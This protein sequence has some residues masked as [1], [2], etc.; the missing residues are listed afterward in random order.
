MNVIV[1]GCGRIGGD[2]AY[3]LFQSGHQVVVVDQSPAAFQN[4]PE[5]FRGRF[6]EGNAMNMD[7][8]RRAGIEEADA[9]AAVTSSDPLNAVIGHLA[10]S[11]YCVPSV[12]VR[13]YDSRW[14][15]MH[16]LFGLQMVSASSWGAQRIEELLYRQE[17][18]TVFSSGNGEVE[19]YEFIV[20]RRLDGLA[21]VDL[22]L[23]DQC[24]PVSI[25]RA[26]RAMLPEKDFQL[27]LGDVVLVGATFE[28]SQQLHR[29]LASANGLSPVQHG[30]EEKRA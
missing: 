13:N 20:D 14:R 11:E 7:V 5:D 29:V 26:G 18:H 6:V 19:L 1:V 30:E 16:E 28:G 23:S 2:L 10:K 9:L 22:K 12:A 8:L 24:I 27:K 3:R 25:T 15:P 17:T 4:L 21:L